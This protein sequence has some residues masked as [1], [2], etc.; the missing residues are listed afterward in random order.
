MDRYRH[1]YKYILDSGQRAILMM[2]INKM[3][4][5]DPN[6]GSEGSYIIRSLYFDDLYDTCFYQNESGTDPRAKYRIRYYNDDTSFIRLEKK[7]KR[8]GMTLKHSCMLSSD[9]AMMLSSGAFPEITSEMPA[10]KSRILSEMKLRGLIPKVIVTYKRIPFIYSA[11][12]VRVTFDSEITSSDETGKFI[13][14]GYRE[15]PVLPPGKSVL[16][17]KW[18]ELLPLHIKR[19][20]Q[21]DTLRWS[22]FSKY[23]TCRLVG[24]QEV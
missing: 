3:M 15:R 17:V 6:A 14:R 9:E 2:K 4:K 11:G 16:E 10:E 24:Y 19:I 8:R 18:D 12:N 5:P 20:I 1:E 22:T 7:I 13:T 21:L 23:Y